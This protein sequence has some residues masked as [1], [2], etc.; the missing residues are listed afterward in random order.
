MFFYSCICQKLTSQ[1]TSYKSVVVIPTLECNIKSKLRASPTT[2]RDEPKTSTKRIIQKEKQKHGS[3]QRI[4]SKDDFRDY[5][6]AK[7]NATPEDSKSITEI[8]AGYKAHRFIEEAPCTK[9][10]Q[11]EMI[12]Y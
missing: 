4:K 1:E 6:I 3:K 9:D 11:S 8:K 5:F 12:K 10:N 2:N 7:A